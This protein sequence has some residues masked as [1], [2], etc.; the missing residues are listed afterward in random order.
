[1]HK[2]KNRMLEKPDHN[3]DTQVHVNAVNNVKEQRLYS[4]LSQMYELL[5]P[6]LRLTPV[7]TEETDV[8]NMIIG[9]RWNADW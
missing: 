6:S 7:T 8:A 4:Q 2:H 1:M 5:S 9:E 3:Q